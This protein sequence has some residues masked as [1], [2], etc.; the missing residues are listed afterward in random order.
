LPPGGSLSPG[1]TSLLGAST[2]VFTFHSGPPPLTP[3]GPE[4]NLGPCP[5][6]QISLV[7]G[8]NV[9]ET[10]AP[11]LAGTITWSNGTLA[12]TTTDNIILASDGVEPEPATLILFGSG[13]VIAGGFLRRRHRL[14][15]TPSV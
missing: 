3:G 11:Q 10:G 8:C 9:I 4:S 13:L 15:V 12:P 2:V 14:A 1:M 5:I 6:I 7:V